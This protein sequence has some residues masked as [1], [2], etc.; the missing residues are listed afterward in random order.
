MQTIEP[1]VTGRKPGA[2]VRLQA[3]QVQDRYG[4]SDM[5]LHRWL[6]QPE[7][8][9]PKPLKINRRNYW[10]LHELEAWERKRAAASA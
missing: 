2:D 9:F 10:S 8:A 6:R 4:V 5:T 3:R 7:L 1:Q